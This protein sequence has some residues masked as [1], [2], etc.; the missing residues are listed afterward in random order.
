MQGKNLPWVF[1]KEQLSLRSNYMDQTINSKCECGEVFQRPIEYLEY[2]KVSPNVYWKWKLQ[3]CDK[4]FKQRSNE[5][6][7]NIPQVIKNISDLQN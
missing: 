5:A 4:C 6:F 3:Y 7:K 2:Q 1:W